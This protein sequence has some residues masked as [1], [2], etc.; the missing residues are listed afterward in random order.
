[1]KRLKI[2]LFLAFTFLAMEGFSQQM[3][4]HDIVGL[5][6][7]MSFPTG[8]N[9]L[10]KSSPA[11]GRLE[12][13]RMVN[14][15]FS[16]GLAFSWNSFSEYFSTRTYKND[17]GVAVTTDMVREI[18]TAP[19]TAIFHYYPTLSNRM[20]KPYVGLGI[21]GQYAE[22]NV[23]FNIYEINSNDWGFVVRPE[24][25]T[26]VRFTPSW[27]A[28]LTFS[29]NYSTNKNKAFDQNSLQQFAINLGVAG[30]F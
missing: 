28:L 3:S 5:S 22:Q 2:Y 10:S 16:A 29:Y 25:G 30:L 11:G 7:E 15:N 26:L 23:Y 13:R 19:I 17:Q 14:Q 27:A 20:V 24:I 6:W 4:Y 8:N 9:F 21:G 12:F 1:M 18:Y